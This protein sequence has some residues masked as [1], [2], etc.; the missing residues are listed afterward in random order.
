MGFALWPMAMYLL[1]PGSKIRETGGG[2]AR[3]ETRRALWEEGFSFVL[4]LVTL[5]RVA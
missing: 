3:A 2:R 5:L 4:G 1:S